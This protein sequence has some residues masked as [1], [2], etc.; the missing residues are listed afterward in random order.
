M[1]LVIGIGGL[2][3]FLILG[4]PIGFALATSGALGLAAHMGPGIVGPLMAET[5]F[6]HSSA[7]L[8][9][10][11]PMFVLMSEYL[12]ASGIARDIVQTS[13]RWIGR[14]P[15]GLGIACVAASA[16]MAAVIGSST[17]SAA[18]MSTAAFPNMKRLQYHPRVAA[19]IIAISGTLAIMIPPSIILVIYG[20]L[21]EQSIGKL[22][23]AG[24][25]PGLLTM[26]GYTLVI[27]WIALRRPD[28]M[29]RAPSFDLRAAMRSMLTVWPILLLIVVVIGSLYGGVATPTE[30]GA[31]GSLF[32]LAIVLALR[33]LNGGT[34]RAAMENT[35]RTYMMIIMII[36]G[37]MVFGYFMTYT[38]VTQDLVRAVVEA[39]LPPWGILLLLLLV[40]LLLGCFLD[41]IAILVL[42]VPLTFPIVSALGFDGIWY[43]I[44]ITKTVEIGLV[45]PPLGLN[46]YVTSSVTRVPLGEAFKG[47]LPFLVV[48]L[49]LLAILVT[50]PGLTLWLPGQMQ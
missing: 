5:F 10:T 20:I 39:D 50:W 18:T 16:M 23:I 22:L 21:T 49:V 13:Y 1:S 17:A 19:G 27:V 37:A 15:G 31:V 7:Y 30:I 41:Q 11:I 34:L 40:Y 9:L 42:T 2:I 4:M 6:E 14:L 47:V 45:T 12:S 32:A 28:M 24:I 25:V 43:G 44:I 46:V 8:L 36:L 48:E 35:L 29:P 26:A 38:Q 3:L 33:R